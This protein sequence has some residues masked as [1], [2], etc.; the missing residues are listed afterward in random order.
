MKPMWTPLL[1]TVALVGMV[2]T[3]VV[4]GVSAAQA[5]PTLTLDPTS[6]P[7]GSTVLVSGTGFGPSEEIDILFIQNRTRF[8]GSTTSDPSGNF[9]VDETIPGNADPG[10][11]S[12]RAQGAVSRIR[13]TATF[14][15]NPVPQAAI[16]LQPP[17][18]PPGSSLLVTGKGFGQ[19]EEID[20]LFIQTQTKFLG[21]TTSDPLGRFSLTVTIPGDANAGD[22]TVRAQGAVSLIEATATFIVIAQPVPTLTLDPASGPPLTSVLATGTNFGANEHIQLLFIQDR[23][24]GLG[25]TTTNGSGA[26]SVTVV[27]PDNAHAGVA[28]IRAQGLT[29]QLKASAT[30]TVT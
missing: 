15:V 2:S 17:S 14:T 30:F 25:T 12:I 3:L 9:S 10:D 16:K 8:L 27:I 28:T 13:A 26:F 19:N 23:T 5:I 18:G 6:G 7:P 11:A 20:V 22:A 29:S 24:Q 4:V 21:S 1:R